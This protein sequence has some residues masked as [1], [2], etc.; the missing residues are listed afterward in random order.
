MYWNKDQQTPHLNKSH[1]K[2]ATFIKT[3]AFNRQVKPREDKQ[4]TSVV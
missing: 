2:N 4:D 3:A 1:M